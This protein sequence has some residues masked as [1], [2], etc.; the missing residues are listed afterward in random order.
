MIEDIPYPRHEQKLPVVLSPAEVAAVFEATRNLKHRTILMTIYS[1]RLRV[2]EL[3][4]QRVIDIDSQRQ[5]ISVRQ[6]KGNKDRRVML[7]PKLLEALRIYRRSYRPRVWLFPQA[8][9]TRDPTRDGFDYLPAGRRSRSSCEA[10]I[11]A[12]AAAFLRHSSV[13]RRDRPAPHPDPAGT[14]QPQNHRQVS[15]R[16][17]PGGAH[18]RQYAG[19][20]ARTYFR[21]LRRN[22]SGG[23]PSFLS[24]RVFFVLFFFAALAATIRLSG[25]TQRRS[26]A[27]EDV[28]PRRYCGVTARGGLGLSG[29]LVDAKTVQEHRG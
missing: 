18:Y 24:Q 3:V 29:E 20:I 15:A 11:T 13:G 27:D 21:Q 25:V 2:S 17:Q 19:S 26:V 10:H 23:G 5:I 22:E 28:G 4:N 6:G 8:R 16:V 9:R 12:Y 7:S 14:P 1:S